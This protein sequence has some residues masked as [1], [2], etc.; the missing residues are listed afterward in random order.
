MLPLPNYERYN[1]GLHNILA[2]GHKKTMQE[3]GS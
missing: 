3:S 1:P 2:S